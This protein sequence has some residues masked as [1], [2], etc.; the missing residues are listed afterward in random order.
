M[1]FADMGATPSVTANAVPPP[2]KREG[3]MAPSKRELREAVGKYVSP[4]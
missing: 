4:L 3:Y 2:S 1:P